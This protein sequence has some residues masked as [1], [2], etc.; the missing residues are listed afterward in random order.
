MS[1]FMVETIKWN[2]NIQVDKGP[3]YTFSDQLQPDAYSKI[4]LKIPKDTASD[5]AVEATGSAQVYFLCIYSDQYGSDAKRITYTASDG[6]AT[7]T[8]SIT[9][10]HPQVFFGDSMVNLLNNNKTPKVLKFKNNTGV[11]ANIQI[12]IGRKAAGIT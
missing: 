10:D 5:V 9:L 8:T 3:S 1:L 7:T 4:G 12:L 2:M 11:D 6:G